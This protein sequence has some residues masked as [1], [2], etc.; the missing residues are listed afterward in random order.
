MNR[1]RYT[2]YNTVLASVFAAF[3]LVLTCFLKFPIPNGGYVHFGDTIIYLCASILPSPFAV[4]SAC[5]GGALSDLLGGY[6]VY[7]IPSVI[8]KATVALLFPKKGN[9]ILCKK[10][11]IALFFAMVIT[12]IGYFAADTVIIYLSM[13]A[14]QIEPAI[15]ASVANI[16]WNLLQAVCSSVFYLIFATSLDKIKLKSKF[17]GGIR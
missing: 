5:V 10:N 6:S 14:T 15:L 7:I 8:I 16:P 17:F 9:K 1:K 4:V 12:V 13:S 11:I 2:L 3:T